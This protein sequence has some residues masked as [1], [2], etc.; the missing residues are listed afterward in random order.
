MAG[1]TGPAH[2]NMPMA[3]ALL[4]WALLCALAA[5]ARGSSLEHVQQLLATA[6]AQL[7]SHV[8][9]LHCQQLWMEVLQHAPPA[10][11][12]AVMDAI[13]WDAKFDDIAA[14]L[15]QAGRADLLLARLLTSHRPI[16]HQYP[17]W[18]TLLHVAARCGHVRVARV[19]LALGADLRAL[20]A[21]ARTPFHEAV[22]A[23]HVDV[24]AALLHAARGLEPP[25]RPVPL[26]N[27]RRCGIETPLYLAACGG[28]APALRFLLEH[29]AHVD[30]RVRGGTALHMA[31][32]ARVRNALT[33]PLLLRW[34][35]SIDAL[36]G[37][38]GTPLHAA[39]QAGRYD[40][41]R[42]LL[43]HGAATDIRDCQGRTPLEL[44]ERLGHWRVAALLAGR[45]ATPD[46][47]AASSPDLL[48][49]LLPLPVLKHKPVPHVE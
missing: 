4:L 26:V 22:D 25:P 36:D 14:F 44:A 42:I 31:A 19:L 13:A 34:G 8:R 27:E 35:A 11:A 46:A 39:A 10:V 43:E 5:T 18:G 41:V 17:R 9:G 32:R 2:A 3:R 1:H 24:M 7:R 20:N 15:A 29:G 30:A 49:Q 21:T 33:V 28:D 16:D 48:Q 38:D 47:V 12:T 23:G 6:P 40:A 37:T 45:T